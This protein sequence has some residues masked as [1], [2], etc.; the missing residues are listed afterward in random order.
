MPDERV[1]FTAKLK[2]YIYKASDSDYKV[3]SIDVSDALKGRVVPN[4]W[5]SFTLTGKFTM[6]KNV[7]YLVVAE[8]QDNAKYGVQY[9]LV[10]I[11]RKNPIEEMSA[12][13]FQRFLIA[14]NPIK[15]GLI[16]KT[17]PD[18]RAIFEKQDVEALTKIKGIGEKTALALFDKYESQ[19]DYSPAYA[20]YSEWGFTNQ[21]VKRICKHF[22]SVD[23]AV[24]VLERNPYELMNVG[25]I[26]FKTIDAKALENGIAANDKRRVR[27]FVMDYFDNLTMSGSSWTSI[28]NLTGF[29]NKE[30]FDCD[31]EDTINWVETSGLFVVKAINGVE[32]VTRASDYQDEKDIAK[33]L[34]RL[35]DAQSWIKTIKRVG[36]IVKGIEDEQGWEYSDEQKHAISKILKQNVVLLQGS[37]GVGKTS[38]MKAV[39]KVLRENGYTVASCALSGKASDNLTQVT[40]LQGRTIHRLLGIGGAPNAQYNRDNPLPYNVVVLDEVSMVDTGLLA[41]LLRAIPSGAKFIMIGD[42]AQLDSIGVGTM[43]DIIDS[44]VIPTVTLETIH[45]QAKKSAIITHSLQYRYGQMPKDVTEKDSWKLK[46][47]NKDLGYVFEPYSNENNLLADAYKV[48]RYV[49]K[50]YDVKDVQIITPMTKNCDQLNTMAQRVVN[51]ESPDKHEYKNKTKGFVLREGDK[52][53]NVANNYKTVDVTG[54]NI[55]PIFNGNT[56]IIEKIDVDESD[57]DSNEVEITVDFDGIGKVLLSGKQVESLRLGYA[58]TVHKSQGSTIPCVIIVL[59]FQYMLNS[60]ELLYTAITRASRECYMLTSMRTLKATI[61][62]SSATVHHSNL[63]DMLKKEGK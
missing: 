53:L 52:V 46:G 23:K 14:I 7:E 1:E 28:S 58:M 43:R 60:R 13:D 55:L 40:G 30:I 17:Y 42:S 41:K 6:M 45:R 18:A 15:G 31:I 3:A 51:P 21:T 48:F 4:H 39:I 36:S 16:N 63:I 9:S 5:G 35:R 44:H 50:R 27:A 32:R 57:Q 19:K 62:K 34:I 8:K 2:K 24:L 47:E 22:G 12:G 38:I 49:L 37:G 20:V 56:G 33:D 59:P 25:G 29:L 61:K 54:E 10:N 11:K 26:G